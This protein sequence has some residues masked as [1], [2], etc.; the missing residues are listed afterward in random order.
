[1]EY[2][3]LYDAIEEAVALWNNE[4]GK[5]G[6]DY[7]IGIKFEIKTVTRIIMSAEENPVDWFAVFEYYKMPIGGDAE[8]LAVY[9]S[10]LDADIMERGGPKIK[11]AHVIEAEGKV[12]A[13]VMMEAF[14]TFTT[15]KMQAIEMK[16]EVPESKPGAPASATF[17][18]VEKKARTE[19]REVKVVAI[20]INRVHKNTKTRKDVANKVSIIEDG[21]YKDNNKGA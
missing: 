19:N 8:R 16:L 6:W 17:R 20:D 12:L 15:I 10:P 9:S 1:M 13:Y 21:P 11:E 4:L 18:A 5:A 2:V 14:G 3:G 7:K